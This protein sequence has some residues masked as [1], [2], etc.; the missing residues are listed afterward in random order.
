MDLKCSELKVNAQV[1]FK[2]YSDIYKQKIYEIG[3]VIY[4]L[5][6]SR[7]VCV[8]YLEGYKSRSENIPYEDMVACYNE[9]GEMMSFDNIKGKSVLLV[10]E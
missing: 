4:V 6:N 1:V 5:P 10:A 8:C 9:N 2:I 7:K 3:S